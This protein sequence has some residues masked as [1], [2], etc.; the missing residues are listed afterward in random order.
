VALP[1]R[2]LLLTMAVFMA[3]LLAVI[4]PP[5]MPSTENNVGG[6]RVA[7]AQG[8]PGIGGAPPGEGARN[9]TADDNPG[10]DTRTV[11]RT[12]GQS[13]RFTE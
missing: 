11:P 10:V 1:R 6:L 5:P 9:P 4:S 13:P 3:L 12:G 8:R 2:M 7:E